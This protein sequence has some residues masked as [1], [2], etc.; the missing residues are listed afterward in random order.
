MWVLP[1]P[2]REWHFD[3]PPVPDMPYSPGLHIQLV[4]GDVAYEKY[5]RWL[6]RQP[7][8]TPK[9]IDKPSKVC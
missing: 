4:L 9:S 5:L 1:P 6:M 7:K 8:I 2:V 3:T